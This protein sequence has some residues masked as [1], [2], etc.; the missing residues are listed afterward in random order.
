MFALFLEFGT[1][2]HPQNLWPSPISETG[3]KFLIWTQ[4][5]LH[6]GNIVCVWNAAGPQFWPAFWMLT[7]GQLAFSFSGEFS[8][9]Q[10]IIFSVNLCLEC[11]P[12]KQHV[13]FVH[14]SNYIVSNKQVGFSDMS[15]GILHRKHGTTTYQ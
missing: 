14:V 5:E 1:S 7:T 9:N 2:T 13:L 6:P 10:D 12:N 11:Q 15:A 8:Q 3:P 4:G